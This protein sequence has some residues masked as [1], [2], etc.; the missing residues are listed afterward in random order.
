LKSGW[1]RDR[2][3]RS[4]RDKEFTLSE[5]GAAERQDAEETLKGGVDRS[6]EPII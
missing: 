5:L 1:V 3:E 4:G 2:D 6:Y